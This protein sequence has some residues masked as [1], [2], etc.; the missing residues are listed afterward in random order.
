MVMLLSLPS[1]FTER[2]KQTI[3]GVLLPMRGLSSAAES[4]GEKLGEVLTPKKVVVA[5][6]KKLKEQLAQMQLQ[7]RQTEVIRRENKELRK[8]IG[9][10]QETPWNLI[11]ARIVAKDPSRWWQTAQINVGRKHGVVVNAPVLTTQGLVGKVSAT[12]GGSSQI[13]LLGDANCRASATVFETGEHGIVKAY[14]RDPSIVLMTY[15]TKGGVSSGQTVI[16]SGL[17]LS[18]GNR[19]QTSGLGDIFPKGIP[20]GTVVDV[21]S[22]DF[23]LYMEARV[24]LAVKTSNLEFVYVVKR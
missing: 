19:V 4:G 2:V 10:P 13:V 5:E 20:I 9:F 15:L 8:M 22:A 24:K 6:N 14:P 23:G 17:E 12:M 18:P 1:E 11:P 21:Q 16:S 7:L 3:S